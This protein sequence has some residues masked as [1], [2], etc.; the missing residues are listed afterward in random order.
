MDPDSP[1]G[2]LLECIAKNVAL[3]DIDLRQCNIAPALES[4]LTAGPKY[5][6]LA[7]KGV[8]IEAYKSANAKLERMEVVTNRELG[9]SQD[10]IEKSV[11]LPPSDDVVVDDKTENT[12]DNLVEDSSATNK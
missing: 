4:K 1:F 10:E 8:N 5:R 11:N 3:L 2:V 9:E 12:I 6:A 7:A